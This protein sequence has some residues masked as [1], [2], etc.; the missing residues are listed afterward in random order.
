V[1]DYIRDIYKRTGKKI[2]KELRKFLKNNPYEDRGRI[3]E[4]EMMQQLMEDDVSLELLQQWINALKSH[5]FF[6]AELR[7]YLKQKQN[8]DN[9]QNQR[10]GEQIGKYR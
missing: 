5:H 3:W 2:P 4:Q 1:A 7:A 6:R 9:R 8:E 10:I